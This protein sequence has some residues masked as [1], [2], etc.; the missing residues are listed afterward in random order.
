MTAY[1]K[2]RHHLGITRQDGSTWGLMLAKDKGELLYR[3]YDDEDL[4]TKVISGDPSYSHLPPRKEF[5]I[6]QDSWEAGFAQEFYDP[7]SPKKYY[8]STGADMRFKSRAIAGPLP[9]T[10]TSPATIPI[11]NYDMELE[12]GWTGGARTAGQ[13][14]SLTYGWVISSAGDAYQDLA[15]WDTSLRGATV[16]ITGWTYGAPGV[17]DARVVIDDGITEVAESTPNSTAGWV[18]F[19]LEAQLSATAT[20]IRI[21]LR[22]TTIAGG[23]AVYFD[24]L[25]QYVC[26]SGIVTVPG[27]DFNSSHYIAYGTILSKLDALSTAATYVYQA[28]ATITSMAVFGDYLYIA[29]GTSTDY[30]YMSTA[31]VI[32]TSTAVVKRFQYFVQNNGAAPNLWGND[33]TNT[34]RYSPNP[35]N[36]GTAWSAATTVDSSTYPI[37]GL[38]SEANLLYV[39]K[40]D[41]LYYLD[42][43]G[44]VQRKTEETVVM[45]VS[46]QGLNSTSWKGDLFYPCG[47]QGLWWYD[48]SEGLPEFISP[49]KYASNNSAFVGRVMALTKDEEYLYAIVDNGVSSEVLAGRQETVDGVTN[50]LWHPIAELALGSGTADAKVCWITSL[51]SRKRMYVG[52]ADASS[53][54]ITS[55][56]ITRVYG[57]ITGDTNYTFKTATYFES[58]WLHAGF[59]SDV[60]AFIKLTCKLGHTY[61]AG[62][63]WTA[64]Y[65]K[66]EDSSYTLI[67]NFVGTAA[68]RVQTIYVP[69]DGSSNKPKSTMMRLKFTAVT[70]DTTK[71]PVLLDYDLR[72]IVYFPRRR[73]IECT[74]RA[75]DDILNLQ[76]LAER[77]GAA[78]TKTVIEEARNATWPVTFYDLNNGTAIYVNILNIVEVPVSD[79]SERNPERLYQMTM[80]ETSLS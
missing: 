30:V 49:A 38:Y 26:S 59:K 43:S 66:L 64:Y 37:T 21:I 13:K 17:A 27:V 51:P 2:G 76:G 4:A 31:Q 69:V 70:N 73:I 50:W 52:H 75:E 68:S 40:T 1:I 23:T 42:S 71:T 62:I 56:P 45:S 47:S 6:R 25:I 44:V 29:L 34:V 18:A 12:T 80:V 67:G 41:R 60:K 11:V 61:D 79:E 78:T 32:T 39:P 33:S 14:H 58:P 22:N 63:Y 57:N 3:A 28:P 5:S 15:T 36:A 19:T 72:G 54:A 55:V 9:T 77:G 10:I 48:S 24:D 20:R 65:K 46:T 53:V 74:V 35:V 16:R 7:D 8:S